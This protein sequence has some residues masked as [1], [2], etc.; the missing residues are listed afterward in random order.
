MAHH[1]IHQAHQLRDEKYKREYAQSQ[2]RVGEN[3]AANVPVN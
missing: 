3:L 1:Q 2:Q